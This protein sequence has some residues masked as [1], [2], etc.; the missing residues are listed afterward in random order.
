MVGHT[1]D[2]EAAK[3][4]KT[5]KIEGELNIDHI[6]KYEEELKEAGIETKLRTP[7]LLPEYRNLKIL[8]KHRKEF[9]PFLPAGL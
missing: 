9:D 2:I 8:E 3:L 4:A 6:R 1:G 5:T 7:I